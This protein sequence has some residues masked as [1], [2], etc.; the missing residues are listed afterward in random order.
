VLH[1]FIGLPLHTPRTHLSLLLSHQIC[2]LRAHDPLWGVV[3]CLC[4]GLHWFNPLVWMAAWLSWRDSE[5]ACDDR[6]TARLPDLERLAYAD[7]IASA[8]RRSGDALVSAD[9]VGASFTDKHIRQRVTSVI[10]GVRGSR[11]ALALGSLAAAAVLV[12]SFATSESEPLPTISAVPP[13]EWAASSVPIGSEEDAVA[14]ARRFLESDFVAENTSVLRFSARTDGAFWH[15]EALR[16][17]SANPLLLGFSQDGS[18]LSYDA[19]CLLD[20]V[21]FSDSSYT[22]RTFTDSVKDYIG[23]FMTAL[24]PDCVWQAGNLLTDARSGDVRVLQGELRSETGSAVCA[25]TLQV[26]PQVRLLQCETFE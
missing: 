6:V 21:L 19:L 15:I 2:H 3:R 20:G 7:A 5:L 26:E 4:C 24:V 8:G 23:A 16:P 17:D 11:P 22:H 12:I 18:F 1:P 25:F 10:R 9:A 14:C 13:V